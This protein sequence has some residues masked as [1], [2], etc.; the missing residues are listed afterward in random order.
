MDSLIH[1][2]SDNEIV[3]YQADNLQRIEVKI[4]NEM[5]WLNR[6]QLALL[7]GRDI[8]TIG[9]H[10]NNA[11]K[12]ELK[13]LPVVAKIATT[14]TDG[15]IYQIQY[16]NLDMILSI[17]YRVKSQAG[18]KFRI[19]ANH[20]L[21]EYIL[22]GAAVNQ[23]FENVENRLLKNE[24]KLLS[25][26]NKMD[27]L[28]QT[29]LPP[30]QGVFFQGQIFDAYQF[31]ADLIRNAKSSIILIDNYVNDSVL[32]LLDKRA[33]NVA[34]TIGVNRISPGVQLDLQRHNAQYPSIAIR[35]IAD[36]HDRFL[37]ID[38]QR[39]Y[40]FGASFKDLGKKLFCFSVIE[41]ERVI[42]WITG[43]MAAPQAAE[44]ENAE[45]IKRKFL[46]G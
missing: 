31:V 28:L 29:A 25:V 37:L 30:K 2:N 3:F 27:T 32:T 35:E 7:F 15:K 1:E 9:K 18:I 19:W 39:L 24:Q 45:E 22:R 33:E 8:K 5:V 17:G 20:V 34:V 10:I 14:A 46:A 38:G 42:R 12:E 16:Y 11:L 43:K 4:E 23:R 41:S 26:E 36:I 21:K 13:D 40:T 44:S 6:Q